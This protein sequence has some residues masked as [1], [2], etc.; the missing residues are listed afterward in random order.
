M[1]DYDETT[2]HLEALLDESPLP[3]DKLAKVAEDM[4]ARFPDA[5]LPHR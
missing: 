5:V 4:L 3:C 2:A 1:M